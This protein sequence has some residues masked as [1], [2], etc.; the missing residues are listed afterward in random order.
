MASCSAPTEQTRPRR[1]VSVSSRRS[2]TTKPANKLTTSRS[3]RCNTKAT[4]R[5]PLGP[6][7]RPP[8][9]Q[10]AMVRPTQFKIEHQR[11]PE[12]GHRLCVS[13]ELDLATTQQL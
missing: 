3:S 5:S 11:L 2:A 9:R 13:G 7:Y 4:R 6:I 12:H 10:V 1:S 8:D